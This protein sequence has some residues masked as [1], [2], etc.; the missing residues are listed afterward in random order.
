MF[1]IASNN[2]NGV[3]APVCLNHCYLSNLY[4][5]NPNYRI[6]KSSEFSLIESVRK[7]IENEDD[8]TR[9]IDFGNWPSNTPCSGV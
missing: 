3:W 5:S 9:H 6:P 7:W 8:T 4:Y 2:N 1:Q